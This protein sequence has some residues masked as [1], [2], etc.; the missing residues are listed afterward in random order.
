MKIRNFVGAAA[1]LLVCLP[2]GA[3]AA[4][5]MDVSRQATAKVD[6]AGRPSMVRG[7]DLKPCKPGTHSEFSR[8]SGGYHCMPNF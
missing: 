7:T 1:I 5:S 8:L 2:A 6:D 4:D 3:F